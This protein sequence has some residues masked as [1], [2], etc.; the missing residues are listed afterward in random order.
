MRLGLCAPQII[1][2]DK[3]KVGRWVTLQN[4]NTDPYEAPVLALTEVEVFGVGGKSRS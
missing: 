4:L 2:F 3:P 1:T